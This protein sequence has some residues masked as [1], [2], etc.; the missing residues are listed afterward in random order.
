MFALWA[1]YHFEDVKRL[2]NENLGLAR[3]FFNDKLYA[4][5]QRFDLRN[6]S[7]CSRGEVFDCLR[8][9]VKDGRS[10]A[11]DVVA[12]VGKAQPIMIDEHEIYTAGVDK[13]R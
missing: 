2:A 11:Y 7:R 5:Q 1:T 9:F 12:K 8:H 4:S 13:I 3:K 10:V 6:A